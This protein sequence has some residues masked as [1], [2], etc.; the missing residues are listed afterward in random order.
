MDGF[1]FF[2]WGTQRIW[3]NYFRYTHNIFFTSLFKY[4]IFFYFCKNFKFKTM[5][6]RLGKFSLFLLGLLISVSAFSQRKNLVMYHDPIEG[7]DTVFTHVIFLSDD[8]QEMQSEIKVRMKDGAV[9]VFK[10]SE[11]AGFRDGKKSYYS[12]LVEVDGKVRHVLLP[13]VYDVDSVAIYRFIQDNGKKRL[14]AGIGK[15]SL[16]VPIVDE[17]NPDYVNPLLT[18]LKESSMYNDEVVG[19]F[20]DGLKPTVGSFERR[21]LVVRTEN[22]NYITRFRWGVVAGASMG[23]V[24]VDDFS[25][26]NKLLGY[27]G[28]FADIPMYDGMSLHPEVTFHPYAYSS[29]QMSAMGQTFAVYNRK[30]LVGTLM[31]RY[32]LRMVKGKWLPYA[33]VGVEANC[34]LDKTMESAAR[35][36]D[37]EGFIALEQLSYPQEKGITMGATAGL[38]VE[39]ILS[40]KHSLFFDVRYRHEL[41]KEGVRGICLTASFNL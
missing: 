40:T 4:E 37:N 8:S 20:I 28:V 11:I 29:R 34:A 30:D 35:W 7:K 32:T 18:Y 39:Y 33:Q 26:S 25:F 15:D 41:E 10:A 23:T 16:L 38:G 22:P 6:T 31:F 19:K 27:G 21:H 5:K 2:S 24:K 3:L 14:Y 12:R 17:Y 9:K 36:I 1:S 13:R